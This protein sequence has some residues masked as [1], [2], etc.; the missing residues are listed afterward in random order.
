MKVPVCKGT[1]GT[2]K[3]LMCE[4]TETILVKVLSRER[5]DEK[6]KIWKEIFRQKYQIVTVVETLEK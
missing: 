1:K 3:P 6:T 2:E 4:T 5:K